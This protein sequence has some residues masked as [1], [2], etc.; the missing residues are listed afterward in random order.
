[1]KLLLDM[2]LSPQWRSILEDHGYSC[3]HWSDV[4]D[5][6]AP[7]EEL[8]AWARA[9]DYVILTHDLDFGAILAAS[10][11]DA[12]S[13]LQ[14]RAMDLLPAHLEQRM[15][16]ALKHFE[17]AL[18]EGALIV[19]DEARLRGRILPLLRDTSS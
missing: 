8:M 2:N 17:A 6:R 7:D 19:V 1:M 16:H 14:I 15:L 12:P 13:V 10:Q 3:L 18:R 11:A 5:A 9:N 4:G